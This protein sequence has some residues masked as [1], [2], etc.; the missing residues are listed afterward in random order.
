MRLSDS[1]G[2]MAG[3][4]HV[5]LKAIYGE[6]EIIMYTDLYCVFMVLSTNYNNADPNLGI[7]HSRFTVP[8]GIAV[9]IVC[10]LTVVGIVVVGLVITGMSPEINKKPNNLNVFGLS[11]LYK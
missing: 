3:V 5:P 6:K 10:V 8:V 1:L 4:P 9:V 7:I 11:R 2:L